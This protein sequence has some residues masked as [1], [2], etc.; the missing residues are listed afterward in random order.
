MLQEN[1]TISREMQATSSLSYSPN[2]NASGCNK[3]RC[4]VNS[5][6]SDL[7]GTQLAQSDFGDEVI[8]PPSMT[9]D[10]SSSSSLVLPSAAA[11]VAHQETHL[12]L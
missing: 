9:Q 1:L 6:L 12:A 5:N 4:R 3:K 7:E 10:F 2:P 11:V 8:C